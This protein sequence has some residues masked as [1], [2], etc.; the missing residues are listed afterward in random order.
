[1]KGTRVVPGVP[2]EEGAAKNRGLAQS[3]STFKRLVVDVRCL[4]SPALGGFARYTLELLAAISRRTDLELIGLTDRDIAHDPGIGIRSIRG[5]SEAFTEQVL[6]PRA[7]AVLGADVFLCPAN[8]GLPLVAPCTTVLTLHDAVEWDRDLVDRPSGRYRLRFEYSSIASLL[9]ASA[10]VTVSNTAAQ[11]LSEVLGIDR[12]R[13]HV[14]HE[15]A[16]ARFHPGPVARDRSV[17][18]AH[19]LEPGYILYVG[20]FHPKKDV[21]TLL[22]AYDLLGDKG[23][24]RLVLAGN[25]ATASECLRTAVEARQGAGFLGTV[26]DD[27]LPAL[28]RNCRVFVFPAVAEGFGLPVAEAMASGAPVVAAASGSLPEVVGTADSLVPPGDPERLR[29]AMARVFTDGRW[30]E[31]LRAAGLRRARQWTWDETARATIDVCRQA[32]QRNVVTGRLRNVADVARYLR[33]RSACP[34]RSALRR[35]PLVR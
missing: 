2:D 31:E 25:P 1:M 30:R 23:R 7:L 12:R 9:S 17:L 16:S 24:P 4:E 20:S 14:I 19:R 18:D 21:T 3:T 22:D 32:Q 33:R 34:N 35:I 8:R 13:L 10:V 15:A 28:Y 29:Q 6:W 5:R 11:S 27:H 26:P